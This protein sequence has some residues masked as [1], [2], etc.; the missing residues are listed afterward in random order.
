MYSRADVELHAHAAYVVDGS[1]SVQIV[2][3]STPGQPILGAPV[4]VGDRPR[5]LELDGDLIVVAA[6][7]SIVVL[8][9]NRPISP[10]RLGAV[11]TAQD[12][13]GQGN[14]G[15]ALDTLR[16]IAIVCSFNNGVE[17]VS[18]SNPSLP[19]LIG[20]LGTSW[21]PWDA[22]IDTETGLAVVAAGEGLQFVDYTQPTNPQLVVKFPPA[23]NGGQDVKIIGSL[24][25]FANGPSGVRVVDIS[26]L[27]NIRNKQ[28]ISTEQVGYAR[29]V[30]IEGDLV[31]VASDNSFL[32]LE[33]PAQALPLSN[34]LR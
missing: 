17:I 6:G 27:G 31:Y 11:A 22:V 28:W 16:Q 5:D 7:D 13:L 24:A 15:V 2:D 19:E 10:R 34:S 9:A 26:D 29:N 8:D 18:Y 23:G 25:V 33:A 3:V 12:V 1:P 4:I 20:R 14:F 30:V 21:N 32:V